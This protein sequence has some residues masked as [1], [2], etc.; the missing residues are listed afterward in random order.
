LK[1]VEN[2]YY[3][4]HQHVTVNKHKSVPSSNLVLSAP[5]S[6]SGQSLFDLYD[7]S[8]N[9][10]EYIMPIN[11]AE[12]TPGQSNSITLFITPTR[13]HL[14]SQREAPKNQRRINTNLNDYHSDP[15][16]ISST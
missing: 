14:N 11:V 4:K 15:I 8:S 7:V 6:G 3:A 13:L 5:A 16:E 2:D 1:N 9:D 10:E 12:T